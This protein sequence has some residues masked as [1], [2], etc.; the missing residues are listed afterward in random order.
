MPPLRPP[1]RRPCVFMC[2]SHVKMSPLFSKLQE[3]CCQAD[4][5]MCSHCLFPVVVTSLERVVITLLQGWFIYS[6]MTVTDLLQVVPTRLIV[7]YRL[8]VISCYELVVI[9]NLWRADDIRLAADW[10]TCT[11][12]YIYVIHIHTMI[13]QQSQ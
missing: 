4:I 6:F 3:G 5:R 2:V 10:L 7:I 1:F 11:V 12:I 9:M 8:F 13:L